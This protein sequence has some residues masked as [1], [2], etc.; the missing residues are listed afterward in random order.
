MIISFIMGPIG[1]V[2]IVSVAS[3]LKAWPTVECSC[4][5]SGGKSAFICNISL[6]RAGWRISKRIANPIETSVELSLG[7]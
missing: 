1:F 7:A 3:F 6:N 2:K 4:L 5:Q